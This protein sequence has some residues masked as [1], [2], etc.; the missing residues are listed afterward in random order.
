MAEVEGLEQGVPPLGF[1]SAEGDQLAPIEAAR[2]Q[3]RRESEATRVLAHRRGRAE[4]AARQ[5][6]TSAVAAEPAPLRTTA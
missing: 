6:G 4:R 1:S 5:A 2:I 3:R